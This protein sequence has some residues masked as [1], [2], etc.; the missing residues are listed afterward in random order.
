MGAGG[1]DRPGSGAV[2]DDVDAL[3]DELFGGDVDEPGLVRCL[4]PRGRY[5]AG[6]V[7]CAVGAAPVLTLVGVVAALLGCVLPVRTGWRA[8]RRH[9]LRRQRR[10]VLG[11]GLPLV[12]DDP[13]TGRLVVA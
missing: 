7:E 10:T 3:V 12:A 2:P 6:A 1:A 13:T 11:R 8:L 4:P 5:G 9:N